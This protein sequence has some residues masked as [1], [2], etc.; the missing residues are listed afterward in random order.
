MGLDCFPSF[1]HKREEAHI[2]RICFSGSKLN[3]DTADVN[4]IFGI[5]WFLRSQPLFGRHGTE[6]QGWRGKLAQRA[7][8]EQI[9]RNAAAW[10]EL[11]PSKRCGH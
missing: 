7:A 3:G 11:P 5:G 6:E 4:A 10:A 9:A 1:G 8:T 2:V